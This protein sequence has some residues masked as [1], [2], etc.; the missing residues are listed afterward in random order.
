METVI[1]LALTEMAIGADNAKK[2]SMTRFNLAVECF[3]YVKS[4]IMN[5]SALTAPP[6]LTA[7]GYAS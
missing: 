3:F 7:V 5:R 2:H 6:A 4:E 1:H